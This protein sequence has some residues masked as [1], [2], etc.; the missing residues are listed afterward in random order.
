[1]S[2]VGPYSRTMPRVLWWSS[3]GG[4]VSSERGTPVGFEIGDDDSARGLSFSDC[5]LVYEISSRGASPL[6]ASWE[7]LQGSGFMM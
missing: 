6:L 7:G 1:M 3:G 2:E 5:G 4:A